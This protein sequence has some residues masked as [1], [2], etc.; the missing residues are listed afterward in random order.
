[1]PLHKRKEKKCTSFFF[2]YYQSVKLI[3][4]VINI[5]FVTTKLAQIFYLASIPIGSIPLTLAI[6]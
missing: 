4:L 5:L 6:C 1:M 3:T 2:N